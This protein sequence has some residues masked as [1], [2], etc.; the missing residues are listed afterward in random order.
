MFSFKFY[1]N[2]E[3]VSFFAPFLYLKL[4]FNL[5]LLDSP[6]SLFNLFYRYYYHYCLLLSFTMNPLQHLLIPSFILILLNIHFIYFNTSMFIDLSY[7]PSMVTYNINIMSL[8]GHRFFSLQLI[9]NNYSSINNIMVLNN[10][11]SFISFYNSNENM[12]NIHY[13]YYCFLLVGIITFIPIFY[14]SQLFFFFNYLD[15]YFYFDFY[16]FHNLFY[17]PPPS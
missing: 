1:V 5:F 15:F 11:D 9:N 4:E 6:K 12:D 7:Y 2:Y 8:L 10:M 16:S 3:N 17:N 14:I 13:E